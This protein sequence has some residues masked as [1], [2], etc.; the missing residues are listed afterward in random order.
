MT[1]PTPSPSS[2]YARRGKR[3]VDLALTLPAALCLV[4]LAL[5]LATAVR[6]CLGSPVLFRQSRP[7]RY[8]TPF[9]MFKFRTMTDKRDGNGELLSDA[10][11]LTAFGQF[12]RSTSLDEIPELLNVI[13]GDMS[14]VG[15]RPLL[16]RYYPY[17]RSEE[18]N[19]FTVRPGIT[20]LAQVSGRNDLSWDGRIRADLEYV[21]KLSF[22]SDVKIVFRTLR[23]V[24][25]R[26]GLRVDPGASMLDFDVERQQQ[27]VSPRA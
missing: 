25:T 17:F 10:Q 2:W 22:A 5:P 20:G 13:K 26:D 23:K 1:G 27:G 7:G 14:L 15:P 6:V 12:L 4:P 18:M 8:G 3:L 19:R 16:M 24:V 9:E 21:S 11:R